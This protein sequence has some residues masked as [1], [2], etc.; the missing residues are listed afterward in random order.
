MTAKQ[1]PM[2]GKA[3]L[4]QFRALAH[5]LNPIVTV[6][7]HGLSDPVVAELERALDDHELI[8]IKLAVGD[9][10]VRDETLSA[11]CEKTGALLIQQIGHTA[12]ILRRVAQPDPRKSNLLRMR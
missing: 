9:R 4:K 8:K 5:Q 12:T 1:Q 2:P 11:L 10:A 3:E 7:G 6:A